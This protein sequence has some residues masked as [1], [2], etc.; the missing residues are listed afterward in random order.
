MLCW[1]RL[2][3]CYLRA[4][5]LFII[6]LFF[7]KVETQIGKPHVDLATI[8]L[9]AFFGGTLL[10]SIIIFVLYFFYGMRQVIYLIFKFALFKKKYL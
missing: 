2:A 4:M 7:V 1:S 8:I 5:I 9:P 3:I 10:L 6:I